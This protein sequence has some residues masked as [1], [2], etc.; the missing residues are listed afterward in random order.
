MAKPPKADRPYIVNYEERSGYLY[1]YVQGKEDSLDISIAYWLE[2]L[3][4]CNKK[5]VFK[6]LVEEDFATDNTV[7]DNYELISQGQ[8][9]GV[10][11]MKVAF[12]DRHPE[13]MKNNLFA[14]TVACNRGIIGKVFSNVKEAEEWLLS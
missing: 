10:A 11:R 3:E 14:E 5:N 8:Q 9:A 4:Y 13:Q 2:I 6:L 1:V 12:V 7:I